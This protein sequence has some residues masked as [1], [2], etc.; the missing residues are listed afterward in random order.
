MAELA[1]RETVDL[2]R[3]GALLPGVERA[4]QP[5][6]VQRQA[7]KP[8]ATRP[9]LRHASSSRPRWIAMTRPFQRLKG[10]YAMTFFQVPA[11]RRQPMITLCWSTHA[12]IT[13]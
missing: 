8:S 5:A 11:M 10:P 13:Q 2:L 9:P 12:S 3:D 1:Q 7:L 6:V 4:A